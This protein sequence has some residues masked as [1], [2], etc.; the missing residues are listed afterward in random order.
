MLQIGVVRMKNKLNIGPLHLTDI[1]DLLSHS[2][3]TL[4]SSNI[5]ENASIWETLLL[6]SSSSCF[7]PFNQIDR[8]HM[9][10]SWR[11]PHHVWDGCSISRSKLWKGLILPLINSLLHRFVFDNFVK[12]A[13]SVK[14]TESTKPSIQGIWSATHYFN[15][16]P[17]HYLVWLC[18]HL[19]IPFQIFLRKFLS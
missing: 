16:T 12:W 4:V 11:S 1:W 10:S 17:Q 7:I 15:R 5:S 9:W 19:L 14:N 8:L 13:A 2:E 18:P 3:K 6:V